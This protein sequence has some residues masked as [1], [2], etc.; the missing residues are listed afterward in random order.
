MKKNKLITALTVG[1]SMFSAGAIA[2]D[3]GAN[4]AGTPVCLEANYMVADA[5]IYH[6]LPA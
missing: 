5:K 1:I 2:H 6:L 4:D 3:G